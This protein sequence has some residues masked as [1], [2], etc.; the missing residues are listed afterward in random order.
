MKIWVIF[1]SRSTEHEVSIA[2][3]FG[4]MQGFLKNT[5]HQVFPIYITS[6]GQ[7]VYEPDFLD[8]AKVNQLIH[9]DYSDLSFSI[10]FS[11]TGKFCAVQKNKSFF[12]KPVHL[13]LDLMFLMLHGKNGEDGTVQWIMETLD[14][15]YV[16]PSVLGSASGINKVAM[17][18]LFKANDIP[19]VQQVFLNTTPEDLTEIE[20]LGYPIFVK[21]ATLGSSIGV[22]KAD[23]RKSLE[24]GLEV[25][26]HYDHSVICEKGVEN[27]V[28]LNCSI[29][30]DKGEIKHSLIERVNTKASFLSF[31]EKYIAWGGTMQGI[32]EK[33]QIPAKIPEHVESKIYELCEKVAKALH[34]DG[35]APR[36]DFLRDEKN[37][38]LY[39]NEINTI[40]WAM[41]I[42][43]RTASGMDIKDFYNTLIDTAFYR[44]AQQHAVSTDFSSSIVD[45]TVHLKK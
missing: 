45:L 33:V 10:D 18:E 40:P 14:V 36:I 3:A 34:I 1:W 17:K 7:W 24:N 41:Q 12:K 30:I 23:D 4:I 44:Q 26:F 2:S 27:L 42:H 39:V 8:P 22:T 37:D 11:K 5:S 16:S 13:D 32:E 9:K 20:K 38:L 43:L 31:D 6:N 35:G 19:M 28:E 29:L 25:A 15:P 21:P